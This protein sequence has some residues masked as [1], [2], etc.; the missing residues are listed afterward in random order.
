MMKAQSS[1]QQKLKQKTVATPD[2]GKEQDA[3]VSNDDTTTKKLVDK[4]ALNE[5]TDENIL[6]KE[7]QINDDIL[8][9]KNGR[10][11]VEHNKAKADQA[12]DSGSSGVEKSYFHGG[13]GVVEDQKN[14]Y[15]FETDSDS[16]NELKCAI[17]DLYCAI[18]IRS[19][20]ELEKITEKDLEQEKLKLLQVSGLNLVEYV[21]TSIEV[22][23]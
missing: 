2:N 4:L 18:K 16:Y 1:G 12:E 3:G 23:M 14:E 21:R 5:S 17:V 8:L 11:N 7:V 20:E 22:I 15:F 6:A 19:T 10:R 13:H 9:S